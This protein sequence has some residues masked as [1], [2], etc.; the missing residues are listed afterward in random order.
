MIELGAK[1]IADPTKTN[2]ELMFDHV[3]DIWVTDD[4]TGN[5]VKNTELGKER[6]V[7]GEFEHI[8]AADKRNMSSKIDMD[9]RAT[10]PI[11]E[12]FLKKCKKLHGIVQKGQP[13]TPKD[14][15]NA[16]GSDMAEAI[17]L[18]G[19]QAV[20]NGSVLTKDEEKN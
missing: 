14:I 13:L 11:V 9:G 12:I 4:E 2:S 19:Y 7:W 5:K 6:G 18:D 3:F 17:I 1:L 8:T 16:V 20:M 10:M 15:A